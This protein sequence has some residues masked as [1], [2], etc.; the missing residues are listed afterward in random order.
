MADNRQIRQ[1]YLKLSLIRA[2][3]DLTSSK[4]TSGNITR[5]EAKKLATE[6]RQRIQPIIP[7]MMETYDMIYGSRFR[8]LMEQ[9]IP[10]KDEPLE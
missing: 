5:E 1:E 9:F 7:D 3:A 4:I 2:I 6:T 10:E 8:R